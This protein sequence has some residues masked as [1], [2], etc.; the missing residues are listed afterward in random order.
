MSVKT[1]VDNAYAV[2]DSSSVCCSRDHEDQFPSCSSKIKQIDWTMTRAWWRS[3]DYS[4]PE[5]IVEHGGVVFLWTLGRCWQWPKKKTAVRGDELSRVLI[6]LDL[7]VLLDV[8][9]ALKSS[10]RR[11][12]HPCSRRWPSHGWLQGRWKKG[13][14]LAIII[15]GCKQL[16]FDLPR[17]VHMRTF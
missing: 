2:V 7:L 15:H 9:D 13:Y 8:I 12:V 4:S 10:V 1:L 3:S 14:V 11:L 16:M 6:E 5:V 17:S